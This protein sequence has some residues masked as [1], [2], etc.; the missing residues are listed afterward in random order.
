MFTSGAPNTAQVPTGLAARV[1][2]ADPEQG[3]LERVTACR[4]RRRFWLREA[5]RSLRFA[6]TFRRRYAKRTPP[7]LLERICAEAIADA[8]LFRSWAREAGGPR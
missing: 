7:D 3:H 5:R 1:V 8:M 6:R 4:S 2:I